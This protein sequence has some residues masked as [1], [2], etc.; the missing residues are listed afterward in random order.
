MSIF[1]KIFGD[2]NKRFL[3][4][5]QSIVTSVNALEAALDALSDT[6]LRSKTADFKK[7]VAEGYGRLAPDISSLEERIRQTLSDDEKNALKKE[8]ITLTNTPLNEVLPDV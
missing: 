5:L 6:A 8:L 7:K 2:A 3:Q 1:A 4:N